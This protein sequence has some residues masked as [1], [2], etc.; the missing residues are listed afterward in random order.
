MHRFLLQPPPG[1]EVDHINGDRL[2]NRRI[3]LR[4]AT[5]SQNA[6]N[7]PRTRTNTS[8]FKGVSRLGSLW[9]AQIKLE[10]K[11]HYLGRYADPAE[12][13][14]AYDVAAKIMFGQYARPNFSDIAS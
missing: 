8:G 14:R 12:A 6:M 10:G 4:I 2:D 5:R 13:A 9:C 11:L 7:R 1:L 3:N